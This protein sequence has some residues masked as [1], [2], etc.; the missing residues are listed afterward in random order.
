M[1]SCNSLRAKSACVFYLGS[2]KATISLSLTLIL[3]IISGCL[4]AQTVKQRNDSVFQIVLKDINAKDPVHMYSMLNKS[5]QQAQS[6]EF[7]SK[8]NET[9]L[10]PLGTLTASFENFFD[11]TNYY[12]IKSANSPQSFMMGINLDENAKIAGLFFSLV[13]PNNSKERNDSVFQIFHRLTNSK[14]LEKMYSMVSASF[15]NA[16]PM[17]KF[18]SDW[19]GLVFPLGEVKNE[20][21]FFDGNSSRYKVYSPK[22]SLNMWIGLD[23]A[24]MIISFWT[25]KYAK[26]VQDTI[27]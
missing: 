26:P 15:K 2:L 3:I 1:T 23:S 21:E 17:S 10:Y 13:N 25:R 24:G 20:L 18:R 12:K 27:R 5:F 14:D 11:G 16:V 6:L 9:H 22:G 4:T 7:I 19:E 8:T